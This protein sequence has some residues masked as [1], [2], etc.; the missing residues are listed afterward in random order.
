MTGTL[1][2]LDA[3]P[4][5]G[6]GSSKVLFSL[7]ATSY[8]RKRYMNGVSQCRVGISLG[9]GKKLICRQSNVV[10]LASCDYS[11]PGQDS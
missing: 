3:Q 6:H 8:R 9:F 10:L 5:A 4:S 1:R 7:M 11:A 2:T